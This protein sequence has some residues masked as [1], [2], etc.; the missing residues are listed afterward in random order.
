MAI[1][2]KGVMPEEDRDRIQNEYF[3]LT[4]NVLLTVYEEAHIVESDDT[5]LNVRK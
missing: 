4:E 3:G 2:M 1:R 5:A